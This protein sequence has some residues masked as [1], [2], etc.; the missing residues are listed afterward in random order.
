MKNKLF[1]CVLAVIV[2]IVFSCADT[3]KGKVE[4]RK[5]GSAYELLVN[6]KPAFIKGSVGNHKMELVKAYGGNGIRSGYKKEFLDEIDSLG[7]MALVNL[8]VASQ[9]NGFDYDDTAAVREQHDKI[10]RIVRET[11]DHPAV[12]MWAL[13]NE[14]DHVPQKVYEPN[15]IYYNMKMW[16]AVNDLAKAIREID[17]DHPVLTVVGSITE[18]KINALITQC[19]DLDLLGINE[20]GDLMDI[21]QWL[22][23]WGWDK[24]YVVTEW[25][26]T[27]FWQVSRTP[28]GY[29]I[30]ET[31]SEKADRYKERYEGAIL[32]DKELCLGSYVFLWRQHQ[33]YTHTW[34]GMFDREWRE[35]EAVDVMRYE[36]TGEW[37]ENRAPRVDSMQ[38]DGRPATTFI[39]LKPGEKASAQV[40]M[41]DPEKDNITYEWELLPEQTSFGYGGTGE[42]KPQAVEAFFEPAD[43]SAIRFT[44]P[45]AKGPYRLFVAG[46]DEGNHAAFANIPFYVGSPEDI[47]E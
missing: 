10:I 23:N 35:T 4:I 11:K 29:S 40:W 3:K 8:P 1:Y 34:F 46:Y 7:M 19:P 45:L 39:Y 2:S 38:I 37:P 41:R 9:R 12:L 33:E 32:K 15:K 20:Y 18:H 14:L 36:W 28:W 43:D 24:P 27:G 25:G 44:A 26:P 22:R 31:G 21:P 30:E 5:K 13:G 16:D 47:V 17:S 6:G 42:K